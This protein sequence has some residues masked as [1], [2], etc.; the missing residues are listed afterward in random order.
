VKSVVEAGSSIYD[1][2]QKYK[3]VKRNNA[4]ANSS[5]GSS[6][7]PAKL[8]EKEQQKA[9]KEYA[10]ALAKLVPYEEGSFTGEMNLKT[11][12]IYYKG[13]FGKE[14]TM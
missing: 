5:N 14:Y 12:G 13:V 10:A 3:E 6:N 9:E 11:I 8:N 1:A 2:H 4:N 7:K